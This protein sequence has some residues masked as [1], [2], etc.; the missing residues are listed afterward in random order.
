MS[1]VA[2]WQ[3]LNNLDELDKSVYIPVSVMMVRSIVVLVAALAVA[4]QLYL[5]S[6]VASSA[7]TRPLFLSGDS[8]HG[9]VRPSGD[10][11][12]GV[13]SSP[14]V[15]HRS[16]CPV[17]NT[18]ANHGFLPRDGKNVT[19]AVLSNGLV[20]ALNLDRKLADLFAKPLTR[21]Y[22]DQVFTLA[23]LAPHNFLE[24]DAS[25][26]HNDAFFGSDPAFINQTLVGSLIARAVGTPPVLTRTGMARYRRDRELE[27]RQTNPQFSLS[28]L[29]SVIGSGEAGIVLMILGDPDTMTIT[30]ERA[31]SFLQLEKF[32]EAFARPESPIPMAA[33]LYVTAQMKALSLMHWLL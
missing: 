11:V 27:S 15:N 29:H 4:A 30:V 5:T 14:A 9:Y 13:P 26:V 6:L 3:Y 7:S 18:L 20:Q 12:S 8:L 2:F 28:T 17:L 22:G 1:R 31:R 23:D 16:P 24:H 21:K 33:V 10:A 19:A 32:P 25:L